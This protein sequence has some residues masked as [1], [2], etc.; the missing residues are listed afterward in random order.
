MILK[1]IID[2][3]CK[4]NIQKMKWNKMTNK[5]FK[6]QWNKMTNKNET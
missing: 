2:Y 3:L 5:I 6:M 4:Y 1:L